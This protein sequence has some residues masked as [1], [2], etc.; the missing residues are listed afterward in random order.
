MSAVAVT[1]PNLI[2]LAEARAA[3]ERCVSVDDAKSIR[4]K[5]EALRVYVKQAGEGLAVQN[6]CAEIKIRAERRAGELLAVTEK[7]KGGRPKQTA[8]SVAGVSSPTLADMGIN[9][10]QS[11]RWQKMAGLP[12]ATF[13]AHIEEVRDTDNELTSADV[14][15][16]ANGKK[17]K[18]HH[19]S[20]TP[21]WGTPQDLFDALNAEFKFTLDVCATPDLA[22]CKRYFSPEKD[23]LSQNWTGS[24]WMNPPYGS[25]IGDWIS[26]AAESSDNGATVVCLVP[27]RVDT[28]WWW[29]FVSFVEVR[30]LRGRL[31]FD[32]AD[33]SA[34]FPS[35]VVVFGRPIKTVYWEW[36]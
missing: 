4:D 31:R 30:F 8:D 22:K 10:Q 18:V 32:G 26:K 16:L 27:A 24:C 13:E 7:S 29:D 6:E 1:S 23:G 36:R 9:E 17:L 25:E 28:A 14:L 2:L 5:A 33:A 12:T 20:A 15:R 34:P 19:S 35:A 21:E 3:V 11:S